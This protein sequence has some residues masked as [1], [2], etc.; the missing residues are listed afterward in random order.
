MAL[1]AKM[2]LPDFNPRAERNRWWRIRS[3]LTGLLEA[4]GERDF[5]RTVAEVVQRDADRGRHGAPGR[6]RDVRVQRQAHDLAQRLPQPRARRPAGQLCIPKLRQV[7]YF[8]PFPE[9][10]KA[11]EKALIGDSRACIGGVSNPLV[12]KDPE[13]DPPMRESEHQP[14]PPTESTS[15]SRTF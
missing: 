10:Q 2:E 6:R 15:F 1:S 4:A 7:S 11:L 3:T 12:D 13:S 8:R 14:E 9:P 5:L